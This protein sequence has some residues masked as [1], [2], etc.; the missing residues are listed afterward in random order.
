MKNKYI[1][2]IRG[3]DDVTAFVMELTEEELKLVQE[4]CKKSKETSTYGCMPDMEVLEYNEENIR[5]YFWREY[6]D[7]DEY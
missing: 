3:C 1:I 6:E 2:K 5:S 7:E 4:L